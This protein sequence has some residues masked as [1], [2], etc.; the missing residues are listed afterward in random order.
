MTERQEERPAR[1]AWRARLWALLALV[2]GLALATAVVAR[3]GFEAVGAAL[4]TAGWPGFLTIIAIHAVVLASLGCAWWA[5]LPPPSHASLGPFIWGRFVRDGG[6]EALPLSQVGGYLIG[7]RAV[8]IHGVTGAVALATT[9]VDVTMELVAQLVYTGLGL[10][11]LV[12]QHP[13]SN[14]AIPVGGGL[15]FATV[16]TAAFILAQHRS[17][18]MVEELAG[19]IAERW[20]G[21]TGSEATRIQEL[22]H[23]LY[24][25]GQGLRW[26]F[27][28]HLLGWIASAGEVWVA[29]RFLEAPLD[30][31]A[32]IAIESLLYAIRS[33]AF[34]VPNAFG[35]QEGAYVML[36]AIFG[37][38]PQ[39][40]LAISLLKRG[41]DL[42][43]GI[44]AVAIWQALE[45]R[46]FVRRSAD[47]PR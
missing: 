44:P 7:A 18:G 36:G 24:Q 31:G 17:V 21:K 3:Y 47:P 28:L 41:R 25:H 10:G 35:V 2:A 40:A 9:L 12:W 42:A 27:G 5:L 39:T 23:T 29:L 1:R 13:N 14:L 20:L 37:L 45:G 6:S 38:S 43:L 46:R 19:Q 16:V 22:I 33:A 4:S 11:L 32:V 15:L 8:T 34:V 30:F 26:G